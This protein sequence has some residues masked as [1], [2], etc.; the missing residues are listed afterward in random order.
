MAIAH[1]PSA[2]TDG[3]IT[4]AMRGLTHGQRNRLRAL[5]DGGAV[6]AE[7]QDG[8]VVFRRNPDLVSIR[9]VPIEH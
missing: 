8:R 1:P 6:V 5:L 3:S 7:V 4:E 9:L 2:A